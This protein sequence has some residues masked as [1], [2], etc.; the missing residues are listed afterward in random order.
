MEKYVVTV[1][2]RGVLCRNLY[3]L[4]FAFACSV[5]HPG[6]ADYLQDQLMENISSFS[7]YPMLLDKNTDASD[8]MWI[9]ICTQALY[10]VLDIR[11]EMFNIFPMKHPSPV[12]DI[13][14]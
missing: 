3:A 2:S 12:F 1:C 7:V 4:P 5:P 11:K 6:C 9:A 10:S 8:V 14:M 13:L